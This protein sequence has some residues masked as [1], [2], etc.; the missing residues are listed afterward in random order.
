MYNKRNKLTKENLDQCLN[1]LAK[2][3][4]KLVG[5]NIPAEIILVGGASIIEN[6]G[7]RDMTT[8]VDAII[9]ASSAMKEAINHV[10][11]K[12]NLPTDWLNADF[13]K[14]TSYSDRI[15]QHS[16]FYKTF[17]QILDIR[18]IK[19]EY[20]IAM[21]LRSFRQHKND[22]SDIAG[23]LYEHQKSGDP[24]TFDKIDYAAKEL[25]GSWDA[26]SLDSRTFLYD[27]MS[28]N[29]YKK[30]YDATRKNEQENRENLLAFNEHYPNTITS[31]NI[32]D[33]ISHL[34]NKQKNDF[35]R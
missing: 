25:Y 11:D 3:Y 33:I 6:Y 9:H 2:E 4:K 10:G 12:Y 30:I 31:K 18:T 1:D 5:R 7:F 26:F 29:D 19:G 16:S 13:M 34:R 35:E 23:I 21:K 28:S 15:I 32:N 24:I 8:D 14:T 27:I 22:V 17:R 20:L